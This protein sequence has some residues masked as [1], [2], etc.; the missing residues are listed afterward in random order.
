LG[1]LAHCL[2]SVA[3]VIA[4]AA[5]STAAGAQL[6]SSLQSRERRIVLISPGGELE[7]AAR[8]AL[9]P[10]D[11]E[12]LVVAAPSPGATAPR[13]NEAARELALGHRVGA[14]VWVSEHEQ[15]YAV[16]VYDLE[17]NQVV[18]RPLAGPP[19]FDGP[20]AAAAALS[21]K[22][23]LRHSATAPARERYGAADA[24]AA[25][26]AIA[27][28]A[29]ERDPAVAAPPPAAA[30]D[31]DQ[32]SAAEIAAPF[33]LSQLDI[34]A[35]GGLRF[36]LTRDGPNEARLGAG[37]AWWPRADRFGVSVRAAAGPGM[38][39][40]APS[41]RGRL[42]DATTTVC[43]RLRHD[44]ARNLRLSAAAGAA[45]H[46]TVLDGSL[47]RDAQPADAQRV[48][49]S[50]DLELGGDFLA[51]SWFRLGLRGAL[52]WLLRPQRYLVHG[53]PVLELSRVAFE[54]GLSAAVMLP[55]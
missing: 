49:P 20:A 3:V 15:G 39:I 44:V 43:A 22:T 41:F 55:E 28:P 42:V 10:W 14:V 36:G 38:E 5:R 29:A 21:L 16:W 11:V 4:V 50:L 17:T 40:A 6:P 47:V 9:E 12:I 18:A 8:T 1:R 24:A 46:F 33:A 26:E 13:T 2:G 54:A 52:A 34:E 7:S 27:L 53:E 35:T 45:A 48:V 23:L 51:S 30:P 25:G 32:R 19:P 37:V 31:R